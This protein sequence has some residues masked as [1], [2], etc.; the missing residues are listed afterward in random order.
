MKK[1]ASRIKLSATTILAAAAL[2]VAG[3]TFLLVLKINMDMNLWSESDMQNEIQSQR[4]SARLEFCF[5]HNIRPCDDISL[6]EFNATHSKDEQFN[7]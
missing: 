1:Q 2:V 3:V 7:F 4:R 6:K 5:D